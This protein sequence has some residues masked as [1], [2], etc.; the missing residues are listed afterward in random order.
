MNRITGPLF[1]VGKEKKLSLFHRELSNLGRSRTGHGRCHKKMYKWQIAGDTSETM[2]SIMSFSLI[3]LKVA[4]MTNNTKKDIKL[5]S[6][7]EKYHKK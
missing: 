2:K 3:K 5:S 4:Q 6:I 7:E 1:K